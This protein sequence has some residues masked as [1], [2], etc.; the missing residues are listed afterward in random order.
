MNKNL[1]CAIYARVS[2]EEQA[3]EGYSIRAQVARLE[4]FAQS[5]DWTIIG[6]YIDEGRSAKDTEREQLQSMLDDIADDQIDVVLV[7][8]LDRLTRSVLDLYKLLDLFDKNNCMFKSATE[9][10]DTTTA[11]GRLF[12]TLVSAI[13]QWER[14]NLGERSKMGIQRM[15]QEGKYKGG[16]VPTGYRYDEETK[17]LIIHE[18]EARMVKLMFQMYAKGH[19]DHAISSYL[20]EHGY[21]TRLGNTLWGKVVAGMIK[22][23]IY[24]GELRY[25][26]EVYLDIAPP[27]I[28]KSLFDQCSNLRDSKRNISPRSASSNY[29]FT[30][31][32]R[33]GRCGARLK[34]RLHSKKTKEIAHYLSCSKARD[35]LC[36]LPIIKETI[37]ETKLL[38]HF[39]E[40]ISDYQTVVP[41]VEIEVVDTLKQITNLKKQLESIRNRRKKWQLAFANDIISMEELRMHTKN[42]AKLH[43]EL[44]HELHSLESDQ[45][46]FDQDEIA[47]VLKDFID[48]WK[49]LDNKEKKYS[50]MM[51]VDSFTLDSPD[52]EPGKKTPHHKRNI[53]LDNIVFK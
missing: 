24:Y 37:V 28:S 49:E 36:D 38:E 3:K 45:P 22:N 50:L 39:S 27:I 6:Y 12:I 13:A 29:I 35:G 52:L 5:Q 8:R 9:V 51:L 48:N 31:I 10:F 26:G 42:D 4:M 21:K 19:G 32:A 11:T 1:R 30:G 7:Y 44:E 23:P 34:G 14:E 47:E 46:T 41:D 18:E 25:D 33:C 2:T 17:K 20:N 53:H 16:L 15:L 43:D 40:L